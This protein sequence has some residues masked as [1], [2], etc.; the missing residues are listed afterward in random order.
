MTM[1]LLRKIHRWCGIVLAA[2]LVVIALSGAVAAFRGDFVRIALPAARGPASDPASYG[3]ALE[4]FVAANPDVMVSA[5]LAPYDLP[6]HAVFLKAGERAWIDAQGQVVDRGRGTRG[7]GEWAL[8]LH[9]KLLIGETGEIITGIVAIAGIGMIISGLFIY[10]PARRAF[11]WRLWPA[12]GKRLALLKSHRNLALVLAIPL[13]LQ[14][15]SGA[16]MVFEG[17]L[18]KL[19]GFVMPKA[20]TVTDAGPANWSAIIALARDATPGGAVR[21]VATPRSADRPFVVTVQQP[22]DINPEGATRV[23]VAGGKVVGI[24]DP[25]QHG[26]GARIL[27]SM[28]GVH[29]LNYIGGLPAQLLLALL[30]VLLAAVAAMGGLAW[31]RSPGRTS[32]KA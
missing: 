15:S 9:H 21:A 1:Q 17:T 13:F 3:P 7:I 31:L 28:M 19:P 22:G 29:T 10:W 23:F 25:A 18:A 12:S 11:S 8:Q 16:A 14:F 4:A 30:G 5:K 32:V 24:A 6:L 2:L 26:A 27:S 20:P